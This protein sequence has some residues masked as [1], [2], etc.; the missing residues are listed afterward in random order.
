[1]YC[2]IFCTRVRRT[3]L[4]DLLIRTTVRVN[5]IYNF[6]ISKK[7]KTLFIPYRYHAKRSW[8]FSIG[9]LTFDN[10]QW[11]LFGISMHY[12]EFRTIYILDAKR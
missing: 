10:V 4:E 1:M 3:S 2:N 9:K 8:L 11:V 7:K 6:Q 12:G 5:N